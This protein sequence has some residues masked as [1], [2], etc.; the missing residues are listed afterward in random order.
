[1]TR[2]HAGHP[3]GVSGPDLLDRMRVQAQRFGTQF[4]RGN[5]Q[6]LSR[7]NELFSA[8]LA[9]GGAIRGRSVLI[10]TGV[11]NRSPAISEEIHTDGLRRG[12]IRYCPICDG[13]E[14]TDRR[15]AV[16]GTGEHGMAEAEFLRIYSKD[17]AL[18]APDGR[19]ALT[20]LQRLAADRLSLQILDGPCLDFR[21][22]DAEVELT[23]EMGRFTFDTVYPALGC[24]IRSELGSMLGTK[25]SDDGCII[26]DAHQQTSVEG[27]YAAG[28]VVRG[29]DQISNAMGQAGVAATAIRNSLSSKLT[30]LRQ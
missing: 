30:Q 21:L 25:V 9:T 2:N 4:I 17:V 12:L 28:D 20:R 11:K 26:V 3:D 15:I 5:V 10:A 8:G 24:D 7:E 13:F 6:S 14:V 1:M 19:H 27:V 16:L 29:L 23:L 18:V 22:A